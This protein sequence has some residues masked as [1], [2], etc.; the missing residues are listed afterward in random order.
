MEP[1][2]DN[3]ALGSGFQFCSPSVPEKRACIAVSA[4]AA[5]LNRDIVLCHGSIGV[6]A[7]ELPACDAEAAR[8]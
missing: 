7:V 6:E 4:Q 8:R 2:I 1:V 5:V 3:G